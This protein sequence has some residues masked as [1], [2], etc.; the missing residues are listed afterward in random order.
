[1][2]DWVQLD[3]RKSILLVL[4]LEW[5]K[6]GFLRMLRDAKAEIGQDRS[7]SFLKNHPFSSIKDCPNER[8][9]KIPKKFKKNS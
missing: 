4:F 8:P 5:R 1:M 6:V 3:W 7:N 2:Q 9:K